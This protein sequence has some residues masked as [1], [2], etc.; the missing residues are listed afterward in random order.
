MSFLPAPLEP[1][2]KS[3]LTRV[4][5]VSRLAGGI[6]W[7]VAALVTVDPRV[8]AVLL[9]AGTLA[10]LFLSGLPL[11]RL[12]ARLAPLL[13]AAVGLAIVTVLFHASAGDPAA[14]VVLEAGPVRITT[15][16]LSAGLALGLRLAVVAV[17]S[18][19]VFAPSDATRFAD[20]LTQQWHLPY[21]I[22]FG[23]LAALHITPQIGVDWAA[24]GAV[25]RLRGIEPHGP[26]GW[27]RSFSGRL[28][29][30]LVSA[31]RRAGRMALAMDARGFDSGTRRSHFRPI[32]ATLLDWAVLAVAVAVAAGALLV[33]RLS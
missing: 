22:A 9:G 10:L 19:L 13:L 31:I 26:I 4:S 30:L 28:M 32:H 25:R 29:T 3:L 20:S 16:S 11:S 8:P 23:T 17:T 7:L 5:P 27:L 12:P 2:R 33:A 1:I 21:R 24:T 6:V 18:I 14:N 15:T